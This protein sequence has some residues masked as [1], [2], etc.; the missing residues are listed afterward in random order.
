MTRPMI[1]VS[2][3]GARLSQADHP[4]V[5]LTVAEIV[6]TTS[7]CVEA[8]ADALH[9][10]VRDAAGRHSIDP[11]LYCEALGEL[12]RTLPNL[13]VQVTSESGGIYTP[14]EQL[15]MIET[16]KPEWVSVSL[17][18][19]GRDRDVARRLYAFAKDSG[20]RIQHIIYDAD[21]AA[22]LRDWQAE[23][24]L[25]TSE[26]VILALGRYD[27][28][29]TAQPDDLAP[30]LNALPPVGSWMVCAFGPHEHACLQAAATL[31]G[32]VRVGFENS[33]TQANGTRWEDVQSS[34][35]AL[36]ATLTNTA[37]PAA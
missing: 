22:L 13:P 14:A 31:G 37:R 23:G 15:A 4:A 35:R 28:G 9:L 3:T 33:T 16:L 10:H 32:D 12:E 20:I 19:I 8:G 36:A 34:V 26:S 21:D 17:R 11:G 29:Q 27:Q 6:A 1:M 18:E 5:P 24:A 30:L 7:A 2:P 25:G